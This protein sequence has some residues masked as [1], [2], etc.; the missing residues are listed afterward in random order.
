MLIFFPDPSV[1][2]SER[3]FSRVKTCEIR[4]EIWG[5]SDH[6]PIILELEGDL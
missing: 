5:A 1:V 3:L 2:V 6:C 4:Y